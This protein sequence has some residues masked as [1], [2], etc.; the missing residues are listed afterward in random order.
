MPAETRTTSEERNDAREQASQ[1][2]ESVVQH[3]RP[4]LLAAL[5]AS[6]LAAQTVR[7]TFSKVRAQLNERTETARQDL[8]SDLTELREKLDPAELRR[9]VDAYTE[10]ARQLYGYLTDRG[11]Q[12]LDRLQAEPRVQ[13]ARDGVE[14]AQ[15]K[16]DDAVG[17]VRGLADD[18]LGAAP[19]GGT[20]EPGAANPEPAEESAEPAAGGANRPSGGSSKRT[21][22]STGKSEQEPGSAG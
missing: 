14:T 19:T 9:L 22:R 10:S 2:V 7:D 16:I 17:E 5:G 12:A 11:E 13:Q 3:A 20:V 6:D 1:A 18:V 4:P 8:P 21:K 15:D